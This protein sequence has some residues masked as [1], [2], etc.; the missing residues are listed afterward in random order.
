MR[1]MVKI[2]ALRPNGHWY[3]MAV[4]TKNDS[5]IKQALERAAKSPVAEKTRKARATDI[6]TGMLLDILQL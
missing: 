2:E 6:D 5:V 1:G 3:Q 4:V